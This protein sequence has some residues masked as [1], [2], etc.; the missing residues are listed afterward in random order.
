MIDRDCDLAF[1]FDYDADCD[2]EHDPAAMLSPASTASTNQSGASTVDAHNPGTTQTQTQD[3]DDR[4]EG[5]LNG[6][7][8]TKARQGR[9]RPAPAPPQSWRPQ[10]YGW[11]GQLQA[12]QVRI[13]INIDL[14]T[15]GRRCS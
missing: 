14:R 3:D 13:G 6:I 15:D 4:I 5:I 10:R 8:G 1:A 2:L 11:D 12:E 9:N 7:R